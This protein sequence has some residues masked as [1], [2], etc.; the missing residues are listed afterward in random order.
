MYEHFTRNRI[1]NSPKLLW[2]VVGLFTGNHGKQCNLSFHSIFQN[3]PEKAATSAS[4]T[5][6]SSTVNELSR[7]LLGNGFGVLEKCTCS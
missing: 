7:I 5:F 4:V 3:W 1:H 2:I 6:S